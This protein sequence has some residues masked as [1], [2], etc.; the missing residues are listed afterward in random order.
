MEVDDLIRDKLGA[1]ICVRDM[2]NGRSRIV[3]DDV[4]NA[5]ENGQGDWVHKTF[6][7]WKDY[8]SVALNELALTEEEFACFGHYVLARLLA[9]KDVASK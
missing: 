9:L 2:G 5:S 7:T 1:L 8:D 4:V 6:V 3:L